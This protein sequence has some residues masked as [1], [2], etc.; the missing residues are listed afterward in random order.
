MIARL[1]VG[2]LHRYMNSVV[3]RIPDRLR[4]IVLEKGMVFLE[5]AVELETAPDLHV[6]AWF[7]RDYQK[8][9]TAFLLLVEVFQFP[10]RT[11]ADRIWH[12]LDYVYSLRPIQLEVVSRQEIVSVRARKAYFILHE[13][14]RRTISKRRG[15][16]G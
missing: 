7:S 1:C 4:Q 6:W 15:T 3:Y 8:Y 12:C 14:V 5:C 9:H 16:R 13:F 2:V 10:M 11:Q